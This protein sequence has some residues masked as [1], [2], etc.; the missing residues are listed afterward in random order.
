MNIHI[1]ISGKVRSGTSDGGA[2][3]EGGGKGGGEG[4]LTH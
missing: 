4:G 2:G 3:D 1:Y